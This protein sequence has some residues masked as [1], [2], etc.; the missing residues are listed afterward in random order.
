MAPDWVAL[1]RDHG[2]RLLRYLRRLTRD[3]EEAADLMQDTFERAMR[4]GTVPAD[5]SAWLYR[6]ASNA[7]ID[8]LRRR[9]RLRFLRLPP[10]A[11]APTRDTDD[12]ELVRRALRSI[13]PDQAVALVLRLHEGRSRREVAELLGLSE[14]GVKSRLARG[15]LNFIAACR[16]IERGLRQ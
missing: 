5:A 13:P 12:L 9:R 7:A 2:P 11:V 4:A 6:I 8:H 16:R 14:D 10:E 15:R 3:E 1:Y